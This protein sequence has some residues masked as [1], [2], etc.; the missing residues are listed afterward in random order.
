V[1]TV[2]GVL[3]DHVLSFDWDVRCVWGLEAEVISLPREEL[4]YLLHLPLWSSVPNRGMLF[5]ISPREVLKDP[6]RSPH[7]YGRILAADINYPMDMLL[8]AGRRWVLDGV[9]RLS[10]LSLMSS[11]EVRVRIHP[12]TIIP[13][14]IVKER[15]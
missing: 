6:E 2:P 14:I 1:K 3:T 5:D 4:E 10:R 11:Q 9:H 15:L 12:E 13:Q 8:Y 7:Q